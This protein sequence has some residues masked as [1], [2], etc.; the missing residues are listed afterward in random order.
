[1]RWEQMPQVSFSGSS[2]NGSDVVSMAIRGGDIFNGVDEQ[3]H[4]GWR[5]AVEA[6]RITAAGPETA[7]TEGTCVDANGL[8][9]LPGLIDAHTHVGVISGKDPDVTPAVLAAQVFENC[10]I[11]LEEG[12]TTIRDVGG[13]DG[14]VAKAMELGHACGPRILPS[15]PKLAQPGGKKTISVGSQYPEILGLSQL[16]V[17]CDG[18]DDV[19][20]SARAALAR[21]ATQLKIVLDDG[22]TPDH[23][24]DYEFPLDD[25]RAVVSEAAAR[26]TYVTAHTHYGASILHGLE[27]GVS[28]FEHGCYLTEEAA[29]AMAKADAALVPTL[30]ITSHLLEDGPA[31]GFPIS[32]GLAKTL[33]MIDRASL[34][35]ARLA[36]ETGVRVGSGSDLLGPR[37]RRRA[38]EIAIKADVL[39]PFEALRSA[40]SVNADIIGLGDEIGS[41]EVGKRADIIGV[42]GDLLT[43]PELLIDADSVRLVILAGLVVKDLDGRARDRHVFR[44]S[45]HESQL[46]V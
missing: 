9:L 1:M 23:I 33:E 28:C 13:I 5:I 3:V 41:L 37:Q 14:A 2:T 8:T 16:A 17:V 38:R 22:W 42:A 36:F 31:L 30:L 40:T 35:S 25:I 4:H 44:R 11:A 15:G 12:F 34:R 7:H 20:R 10:R 26:R 6:G 46:L 43:A 24:G 27:G 21:G 32:P 39:S 19:R 18:V 29:E 45:T